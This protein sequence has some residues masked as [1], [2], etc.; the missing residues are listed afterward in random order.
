MKYVVKNLLGILIIALSLT[1][2]N[3]GGGSVQPIPSPTP[4][5]GLVMLDAN[6]GG[7]A[8]GATNVSRM[9]LVVLQFSIAVESASVNASN[10]IIADNSNGTNP[11]TLTPIIAN[12]ANTQFHF[13]TVSALKANTLYY[14][15]VKNVQG[16]DG[17]II[18]G[19]FS[20]ITGVGTNPAVSLVDPENGDTN[21]WNTAIM[22]VHFS[23]AVNNVN[24]INVQLNA[25]S[26][27]G[28]AVPISIVES[29]TQS[30]V[31]IITPAAPLAYLTTY[32]LTF[33][34]GITNGANESIQPKTFSFTTTRAPIFYFTNFMDVSVAI[35]SI[36]QFGVLTGCDYQNLSQ[37][38]VTQP[39]AT[40]IND[41][42]TYAYISDI[43]YIP[44]SFG[45]VF[46]CNISA[47][48][49]QLTNCADS[50]A[51]NIS[52][53]YGIVLR[54]INNINL[55]YIVDYNIP[56]PT[57]SAFVGGVTICNVESPSGNLQNCSQYPLQNVNNPKGLYFD[58]ANK[59]A[60]LTNH[61]NNQ[62][63]K[64]SIDANGFLQ[65][66]QYMSIS[67][68]LFFPFSLE[69]FNNTVFIVNYNSG[70]GIFGSAVVS[71]SIDSNG[72]FENCATSSDY[73]SW[74]FSA[75]VNNKYNGLLYLLA[76][77][78]AAQANATNFLSCQPF[79][80]QF[81]NFYCASGQTSI[82]TV[83]ANG[84]NFAAIKY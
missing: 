6:A 17:S 60:Y 72:N 68:Q 81:D 69:I 82:R 19:T 24:T 49:N 10:V 43:T 33:T 39:F 41:T 32:Y 38:G 48:N 59:Y 25:G 66:C 30:N 35:C 76:D 4:V 2:I 27:A 63:T 65:N 28:S 3:C 5:A 70:T 51:N 44:G 1:L 77:T 11:V 21:V 55:A 79:S 13:S 18:N 78:N 26:Q 52:A 50:G 29:S 8:N 54:T 71:C 16:T 45:L 14:V 23:Q 20:F 46:K 40:V 83:N 37:Y 15:L 7:I 75:L 80:L 62:I 56:N 57:E 53:P 74:S 58:A 34:A 64:C 12:A 67:Q 47:S 36:D 73:N 84:F 31:Y 9:P 61:G 22:T 42:N